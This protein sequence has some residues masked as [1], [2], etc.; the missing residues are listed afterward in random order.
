[1]F[2]NS[3]LAATPLPAK[4]TRSNSLQRGTKSNFGVH[5][6]VMQRMLHP[7]ATDHSS[8]ESFIFRRIQL[9]MRSLA[10]RKASTAAAPEV[11]VNVPELTAADA[12]IFAL[13]VTR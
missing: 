1:M 7:P 11:Q 4:P 13:E 3:N 10:T 5:K 9:F 6:A 8:V 12:P 2:S